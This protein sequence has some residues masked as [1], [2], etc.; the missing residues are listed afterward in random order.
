MGKTVLKSI[1]L[2][3][4][5]LGTVTMAAQRSVTLSLNDAIKLANDSSLTVFRYQNLYAAGYWQ[6]R[7]FK[8]NR[9]PSLTLDITP[10]QYNRYITQ[11]YNY[12]ENIDVFRGQQIYMASA[13][14]SVSQNVD[15]LG[16][17]FYLESDLEYMRNFGDYTSNQFSSIPV[18]MGY[19]QSLIGF[20]AFKWE[21]KIEPVAYEKVKRQ[22]IY[23][24]ESV[25]EDVVTY[26]FALALAQSEYNLAKDNLA[27]CDTLYIVGERRF[28]IASISQ[29]DLLTLKLDKVNAE[30]TLE[31]ARI[32]VKRAR[33]ALASYL[34]MDTDTEI[35]V[36]MPGKPLAMDILLGDALQ[37]AR[38]N[39]PSLLQHRQNV[40]ESQRDV[41]RTKAEA[42]F[43][44]S[45]NASVGFNQVANKLG[46]AYQNLMRQDL[47]SLTVSIP[48]VDWG[49]RKGKVN[50][51]VNNLNVAE[52]AARQE[53]LTVEQDVTMTVNDF[54]TQQRLVSS[55]VEA[56]DLADMAYSQTRQRFIIGKADIN[57]LTLAHNRQ[58]EA[59]RNYI[60][61]LKNY[62]LSYYKIRKLTLF[63][64][65]MKQPI[66]I[67]FDREIGID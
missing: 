11:R 50:T 67:L 49:V 5:L 13:G 43:N 33:F 61:S 28:K 37:Y 1:L 23:N 54:S 20:N 25:A 53:E 48:L 40:L 14:L 35:E 24:M 38:E 42:R 66:S 34:G 31:N 55:A 8:A 2:A 27:S 41:S 46:T 10:A 18:R 32:D 17:T 44:A 52:I 51:A 12:E 21:K 57:S 7:T 30:N 29:A 4:I 58:Q 36:K 62:W 22:F 63:D 39:N 26:F 45:I 19:R 65:E 56:L 47:V 15:F 16:G 60:N 59:S 6:W 3:F 9:L 64:F